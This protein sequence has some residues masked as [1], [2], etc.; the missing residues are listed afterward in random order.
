M[1]RFASTLAVALRGTSARLGPAVGGI[2]G[3][4]H[5]FSSAS[6]NDDDDESEKSS[7]PALTREEV[8]ARQRERVVRARQLK[9]LRV[10]WAQ[11]IA[12]EAAAQVSDADAAAAAAAQLAKEKAR[13]A[14]ARK[15]A[16][17]SRV[18]ASKSQG[19]KNKLG[20]RR[21]RG[22]LL[23]SNLSLRLSSLIST[24]RERLG[25]LL[26][27]KRFCGEAVRAYFVREVGWGSSGKVVEWVLF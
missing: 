13:A 6:S 25:C 17:E 4:S 22:D 9:A 18:A 8:L 16:H 11:E 12:Q 19:K 15:Q 20:R 1:L 10:E 3:M 26:L 21:S 23:Q 24:M 5:P 7:A 27:V 14:Y 2:S